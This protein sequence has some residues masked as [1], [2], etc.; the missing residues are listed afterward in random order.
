M[1]GFKSGLTFSAK[2]KSP[3]EIPPQNTTVRIFIVCGWIHH[4]YSE[5]LYVY[6]VEFFRTPDKV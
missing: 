3:I 4:F 2:R 1:A 6:R 5:D